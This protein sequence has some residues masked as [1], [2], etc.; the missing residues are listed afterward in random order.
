VGGKGSAQY[1]W[2][3]YSGII[4]RDNAAHIPALV[5]IPLLRLRTVRDGAWLYP[6]R[7]RVN[8]F[9]GE[10]LRRVHHCCCVT[11]KIFGHNNENTIFVMVYSMIINNVQVIEA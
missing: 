10:G 5:H 7:W 1:S 9:G 11:K 6:F 8:N 4:A 3:Q 2:G